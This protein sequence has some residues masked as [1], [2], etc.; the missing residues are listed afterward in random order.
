MSVIVKEIS[1]KLK[2]TRIILLCK[3]ADDIILKKLGDFP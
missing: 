3:G 1:K 2:K